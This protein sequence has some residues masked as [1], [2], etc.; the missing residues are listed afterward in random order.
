MTDFT[1][2]RT[3]DEADRCFIIDHSI[4]ILGAPIEPKD[5][6]TWLAYLAFHGAPMTIRNMW[7]AKK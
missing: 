6:L 1:P 4:A 2:Y 3:Q 5:M 7:A